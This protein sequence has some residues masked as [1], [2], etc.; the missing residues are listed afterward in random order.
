[1]CISLDPQRNEVGGV[2]QG[3]RVKEGV[4]VQFGQ[5]VVN[6]VAIIVLR[7]LSFGL[8]PRLLLFRI[9]AHLLLLICC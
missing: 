7:T 2:V 4:V 8:V 9:I 1:M 3:G 6:A 5:G